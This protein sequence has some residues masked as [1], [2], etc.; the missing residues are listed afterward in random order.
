[1]VSGRV[2]GW[3][4]AVAT[5]AGRLGWIGGAATTRPAEGEPKGAATTSTP[6]TLTQPLSAAQA[7]ALVLEEATRLARSG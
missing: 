4:E 6:W 3:V 2:L 7:E 5:L 1:M